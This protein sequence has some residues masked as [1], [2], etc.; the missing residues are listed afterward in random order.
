MGRRTGSHRPISSFIKR[1]GK[2]NG[3]AKIVLVDKDQEGVAATVT[4]VGDLDNDE[5]IDNWTSPYF[6][7]SA[8]RLTTE[9][10]PHPALLWVDKYRPASTESLAVHKTKLQ[11]VRAWLQDA[12]GQQVGGRWAHKGR[13]G[14]GCSL[15]ARSRIVVLTGPP[16]AGKTAT[17]HCLGVELGVEVVEYVNPTQSSWQ[18]LQQLWELSGEWRSE[19][20]SSLASFENFLRQAGRYMSVAT[21]QQRI[22]LVEDLP[23]LDTNLSGHAAF[24][25]A[26][27]R[28]LRTQGQPVVFIVS[29]AHTQTTDI[30]RIFGRQLIDSGMVE[31]IKFNGVATTNLYKAL[32][33]VIQRE[34]LSMAKEELDRVVQ[35]AG[36]DIRNALMTL[37]FS[38]ESPG[39]AAVA[40]QKPVKKPRLRQPRGPTAPSPTSAM[41]GGREASLFVFHA[42]GKVLH[43]KREGGIKGSHSLVRSPLLFDPEDV[44]E[45]VHVSGEVF[46]LFL[47]ENY[48]PFM[49]TIDESALAAS[50]LSDA[51]L[52]HSSK[53]A[54]RNSDLGTIGGLVAIRGTAFANTRHSVGDIKAN[55]P[56]M[57]LKRT[58]WTD[59]WRS[60]SSL[61][62]SATQA[63]CSPKCTAV[64][65]MEILMQPA[66]CL[67]ATLPFLSV[68]AATLPGMA[69]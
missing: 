69:P 1:K 21:S 54:R 67:S 55:R 2:G 62:S 27:A 52:L 32:S 23:N 56:W 65:A 38:L 26:L 16:G 42:L 31:E 57:S 58:R 14:P 15:Q 49:D 25:A 45:K 28:Y 59:V 43:C 9:R 44:L 46:V 29:Q 11:E 4:P 33:A 63:I 50:Y 8:S 20:G 5:D 40:S 36:G 30:S 3:F 48:L 64:V 41:I 35:G 37:Q 18:S 10:V 22:L 19:G 24:Q 61:K 39:Q 53:D 12:L 13:T 47:Q 60:A 34:G 66:K 7:H 6:S 17:V 68:M 51:D